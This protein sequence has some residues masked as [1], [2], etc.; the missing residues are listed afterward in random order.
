MQH[1]TIACMHGDDNI[2][3]AVKRSR[4][5]VVIIHSIHFSLVEPL[6]EESPEA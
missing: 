6:A 1:Y 3:F 4:G 5:S 2:D